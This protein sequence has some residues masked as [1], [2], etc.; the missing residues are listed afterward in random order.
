MFQNNCLL[1]ILKESYD[2]LKNY[3]LARKQC[4]SWS[5]ALACILFAASLKD[6]DLVPRSNTRQLITTENSSSRTLLSS[7]STHIYMAESS[8]MKESCGVFNYI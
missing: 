2:S 8:H 5:D 3:S 6:R 4:R 7:V 1:S